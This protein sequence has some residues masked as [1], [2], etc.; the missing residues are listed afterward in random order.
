MF[1]LDTDNI[2]VIFEKSFE[3][4]YLYTNRRNV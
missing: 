2:N 1:F 4:L 3:Y